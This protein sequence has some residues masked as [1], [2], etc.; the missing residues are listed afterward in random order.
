MDRERLRV[1]TF[2]SVS[3]RPGSYKNNVI[4]LDNI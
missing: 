4:Q 3:D 2:S 1:A